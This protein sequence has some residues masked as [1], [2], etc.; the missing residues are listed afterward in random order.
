MYIV[1]FFNGSGWSQLTASSNEAS[2]IQ[3]ADRY[4]SRYDSV[5]VMC[6]GMVVYCA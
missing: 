1:Q 4:A 6:E 2:A 5:R 3:A